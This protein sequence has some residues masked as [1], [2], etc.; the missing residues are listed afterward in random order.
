MI[1]QRFLQDFDQVTTQLELNEDAVLDFAR[2]ETIC[3]ELGFYDEKQSSKALLLEMWNHLQLEQREEVEQDTSGSVQLAHLKVFLAAVLNFNQPWMK[4]PDD[5]EKPRLNPK[6]IGAH[7]EG[8]YVLTDE[9]IAFITKRFVLIHSARQDHL[10][11]GKKE[12][13]LAKISQEPID[14][15]PRTDPKSK[16]ILEKKDPKNE[17][18]QELSYHDYLIKRGM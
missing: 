10:L 4:R 18:G 11:N 15:R 17:V 7:E 5:G 2:M 13:H 16:K 12:M 9:E 3:R 8:K 6:K 14:F 1:L